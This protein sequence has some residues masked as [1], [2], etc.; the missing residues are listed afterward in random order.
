MNISVFA[1]IFTGAVA[2]IG[3]VGAVYCEVFNNTMYLPEKWAEYTELN[4]RLA[5][6]WPAITAKKDAL[7]DADEWKEVEEKREHLSEEAAS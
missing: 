5:Q 3:Y 2:P 6:S 1:N 7:P 4:A